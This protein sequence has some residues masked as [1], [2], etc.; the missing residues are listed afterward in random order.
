MNVQ[1]KKRI[2]S[3][4][5]KKKAR[6]DKYIPLVNI[7]VVIGFNFKKTIRYEVPNKIGKITTKPYLKILKELESNPEW[8]RQG[9]TLV[10]DADS[11]HTANAVKNWCKSNDFKVITLPRKL[12]QTLVIGCT[13][14]ERLGPEARQPCCTE[15]PRQGNSRS[16]VMESTRDGVQEVWRTP[17]WRTPCQEGLLGGT[18]VLYNSG[19]LPT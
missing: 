5:E 1:K 14:Q 7:F 13:G 11:A 3:K 2:T 12:L 17:V 16:H 10:Q 18:K 4:E 9:L 8:R 6:E 19:C 15:K